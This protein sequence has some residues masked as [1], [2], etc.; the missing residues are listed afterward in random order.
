MAAK[1]IEGHKKGPKLSKEEQ[2][3][4]FNKFKEE[5]TEEEQT[6]GFSFNPLNVK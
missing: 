4:E 1:P 6:A 2:L 3:K 5:K